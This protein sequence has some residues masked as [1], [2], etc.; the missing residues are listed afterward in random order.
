[1]N[2]HQ[3]ILYSLSLLF[4][5]IKNVEV[6]DVL[7]DIRK[8]KAFLFGTRM[9]GTSVFVVFNQFNDNTDDK[10]RNSIEEQYLERENGD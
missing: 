9:I 10:Q 3:V 6:V 4:K 8:L 5:S 1:M 2:D 7:N